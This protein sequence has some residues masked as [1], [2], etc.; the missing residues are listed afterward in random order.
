MFFRA[1][2]VGNII[3]NLYD[4]VIVP[5]Y[6]DNQE[7]YEPDAQEGERRES[8]REMRR[9][10]RRDAYIQDVANATKVVDG[11]S[12]KN[13]EIDN[14]CNAN[15]TRYKTSTTMDKDV[16]L[17]V[18]LKGVTSGRIHGI[19]SGI[20]GTTGYQSKLH[21]K[22]E[23]EEKDG[24]EQR[25][26]EEEYEEDEEKFQGQER[27]TRLDNHVHGAVA[28][29]THMR[30]NSG[31]GSG[32]GHSNR[33]PQSRLRVSKSMEVETGESNVELPS[34]RVRELTEEGSYC[35]FEGGRTGQGGETG[36]RGT[37]V[38]TPPVDQKFDK[39]QSIGGGNSGGGGRKDH[40]HRRFHPTNRAKYHRDLSVTQFAVAED[41]A[42][43]ALQQITKGGGAI[44]LVSQWKSQ[45]DDSEET[46]HEME[47]AQLQSP[48]HKY[49]RQMSSNEQQTGHP[50]GPNSLCDKAE[51]EKDSSSRGGR[52]SQPV[53]LVN[54]M[55]N[56]AVTSAGSG[57]GDRRRES[58]EVKR[59]LLLKISEE[60]RQDVGLNGTTNTLK[61][62][63]RPQALTNGHW[64][65][66]GPSVM[67]PSPPPLP[68]SPASPPQPE[69]PRRRIIQATPS[70]CNGD[71]GGNTA[72][73][74]LD[75]L[76]IDAEGDAMTAGIPKVW[77]MPQL[78]NHIR[79]DLQPPRLQQA[80]F[81]EIVYEVDVTRNVAVKQ[82]PPVSDESEGG[83][84]PPLERLNSQERRQS[85]P[86]LSRLFSADA[87]TPSLEG[88]NGSLPSGSN[89]PMALEFKLEMR[90]D[91]QGGLIVTRADHGADSNM[92]VEQIAASQI[93]S[94]QESQGAI[95]PLQTSTDSE[96]AINVRKSSCTTV[97]DEVSVYYDAP[98]ARDD[99]SLKKV[100]PLERI[101]DEGEEEFEGSREEY[102]TPPKGEETMMH[103][104]REFPMNRTGTKTAVISLCDLSA[105]FLKSSMMRPSR[106]SALMKRRQG[107]KA[108]SCATTNGHDNLSSPKSDIKFEETI[109]AAPEEF[110]SQTLPTHKCSECLLVPEKLEIDENEVVNLDIGDRETP[111]GQSAP[112]MS[113]CETPVERLPAAVIIPTA[114]LSFRSHKPIP[115]NGFPKPELRGNANGSSQVKSC[116]SATVDAA[117]ALSFSKEFSQDVE[118]L[119]TSASVKTDETPMA[120]PVPK[121]TTQPKPSLLRS[122]N[123]IRRNL[124][125]N[126]K[127]SLQKRNPDSNICLQTQS[128]IRPPTR[129]EKSNSPLTDPDKSNSESM[130]AKITP[131][132]IITKKEPIADGGCI[133]LPPTPASPRRLKRKTTIPKS[134]D[135][136][137][138]SK[139]EKP[140]VKSVLHSV[141]GHNVHT[142]RRSVTAPLVVDDK[143]EERERSERPLSAEYSSGHRSS[144][145]EDGGSETSSAGYT[146]GIR[147]RRGGIEK[148][149]MD[150]MDSKRYR[151]RRS[152]GGSGRALLFCSSDEVKARSILRG[153]H[154][155]PGA[156]EESASSEGKD[157]S[158]SPRSLDPVILRGVS[159]TART[160]DDAGGSSQG[161]S[162]CSSPAHL[163]RPPPG[164]PPA[165]GCIS[166]R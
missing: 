66:H 87:D 45:F 82:S 19:P 53:P 109:L 126:D 15:I 122:P 3:D 103:T 151:R 117:T 12:N 59:E 47:N 55:I 70:N 91:T 111:E 105:A 24:E 5:S 133:N 144:I 98:L 158:D 74:T 145:T 63:E 31:G 101:S 97:P 164:D 113:P 29:D 85:L 140:L 128:L 4:D 106:G 14:N 81:D 124:N 33:R 153:R 162:E 95:P 10:H 155:T 92:Q 36:S 44:T 121:T 67:P 68:Q 118:G 79:P 77:S 104:A 18:E 13:I 156:A 88:V 94:S 49:G 149:V 115:G 32:G 16:I 80:T 50:L 26:E 28:T 116:V 35:S 43:S 58:R 8:D 154:P 64:N 146:P 25:E 99:V 7:N 54:S 147:R 73:K 165:H 163:P 37:P 135:A 2:I 136:I 71:L 152:S 76:N 112:L 107:L 1:P 166:A 125:Q 40:K 6:Q 48:E 161:E 83:T 41:D 20:A 39:D 119:P 22:H 65:G 132:A 108:G 75:Y 52:S 11:K 127:L 69:T 114:N 34:P 23:A 160:L 30:A 134:D 60:S 141:A 139:D 142:I 137:P 93:Q 90:L 157:S 57:T 56:V 96:A 148:Y 159:C 100:E 129:R 38:G 46:D 62:P 110:S 138:P 120:D 61:S 89:Q 86:S 42:V 84:R 123:A 21:G 17:S 150:D 27:D 9:R 131:S 51:S 130:R 72:A 143:R 102:D 78:S